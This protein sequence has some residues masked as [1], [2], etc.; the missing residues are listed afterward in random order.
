MAKKKKLKVLRKKSK[1]RTRGVK[2]T[3]TLSNYEAERLSA[4]CSQYG[5]K[6][7]RQIAKRVLL[8]AA[9]LHS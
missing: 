9:G 1:R 4:K 8:K 5:D 7:F 6:T 3:I 2:I